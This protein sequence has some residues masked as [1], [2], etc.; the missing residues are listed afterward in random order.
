MEQ[1]VEER[2]VVED[3]SAQFLGGCFAAAVAEG[4]LAR[5]AV[6]VDD[7]WMVDGDVGGALIEVCD[8]IATS[9]H[10]LFDEA[11]GLGDGLMRLVDE[12]RLQD[13]PLSDEVLALLGG[14]FANM[15]FFHAS[16]AVEQGLFGAAGSD[17]AHGAFVLGTEAAL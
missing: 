8:G 9:E 3:C 6:V 2:A 5:G 12:A 13:A 10:E 17:F 4:D 1:V 16:C 11:V 14:E 15:K 7:V